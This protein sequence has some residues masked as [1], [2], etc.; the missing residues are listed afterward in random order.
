M[1]GAGAPAGFVEICED[2]YA[3]D[4]DGERIAISLAT[5]F[6][7]GVK[8]LADIVLG[9]DGGLPEKYEAADGL[10]ADGDA[11]EAI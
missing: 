2:P 5:S 9:T 3:F 10:F 6:G 4:R 11:E 8:K 7:T 1:G